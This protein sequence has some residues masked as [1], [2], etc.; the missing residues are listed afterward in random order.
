M[1]RSPVRCG[2]T[3]LTALALSG[4]SVGAPEEPTTPQQATD[5]DTRTKAASPRQD[6]PEPVFLEQDDLSAHEANTPE[7]AVL[8]LWFAIQYRDML[9]A[10]DLMAKEFRE[11]FAQSLPHFSEFVMA[12][13]PRWRATPRILFS[14]A[15]SDGRRM[16]AVAYR[17]PDTK[18]RERFAMTFVREGGAWKLAYDF[19]LAQRLAAE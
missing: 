8:D 7:R 19:Y 3:L 1:K 12:D 18:S 13:Y 4:C 16:V 6:A 9:T 2:A 15:T 17:R 11:E 14:R 5:S 10:Y